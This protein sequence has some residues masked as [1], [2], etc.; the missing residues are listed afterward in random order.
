MAG[1]SH[2]AAATERA[3]RVIGVAAEER[4]YRP[5][6]TWQELIGEFLES[7]TRDSMIGSFWASSFALYLSAAGK[8]TKLQEFP[9]N[10]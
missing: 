5:H 2:L 7:I 4:A 9:L 8:Y 6:I 1:N 10:S 3:V